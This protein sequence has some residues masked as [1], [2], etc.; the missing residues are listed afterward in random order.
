[1]ALLAEAQLLAG[2]LVRARQTADDAL[3]QSHAAGMGFA[4]GLARRTLGRIAHAAGELRDAEDHLT[5][6]LATLTQCHADFEAART[7]MD[8]AAVRAKRGDHE[9]ARE[10]LAAALA[11]F[12]AANVPKRAA[13]V[14]ELARALDLTLSDRLGGSSGSA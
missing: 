1:M 8:L 11:A 7:R 10:D 3:E 13:Q 4:T 14:R 2:D 9:A 12:E 5:G 6:A